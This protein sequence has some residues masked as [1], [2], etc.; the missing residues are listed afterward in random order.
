MK[1][2]VP[3]GWLFILFSQI[4]IVWIQ[5]QP[6][7]PPPPPHHPKQPQPKKNRL[8]PPHHRTKSYPVFCKEDW[9]DY[10]YVDKSWAVWQCPFSPNSV[11]HITLLSCC[12][13][14]FYKRFY[15]KN[16]KNA[17]IVVSIKWFISTDYWRI[18]PL[19]IFMDSGCKTEM[20]KEF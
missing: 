7:P 3:K 15:V 5:H 2:N 11:S 20:E 18:N 10:V 6:P 9:G 16:T 8:G 19:F 1:K 14:Q 13:Y 4:K 17:F 12:V